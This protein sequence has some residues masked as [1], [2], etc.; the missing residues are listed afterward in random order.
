MLHN[1]NHLGKKEKNLNH[2]NSQRMEMK[3][4]E[5][6]QCVGGSHTGETFRG[7]FLCPMPWD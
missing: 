1:V 3:H 2:S 6:A 4:Q 5:K 7:R